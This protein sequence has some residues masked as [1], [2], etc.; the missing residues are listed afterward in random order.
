[1]LS[2]LIFL[3]YL[4]SSIRFSSLLS[5]HLL[6]S[7]LFF[8]HLPCSP[9]VS[10]FLFASYRISLHLLFYS[11]L[12]FFSH[13]CQRDVDAVARKKAIDDAAAAATEA[14][15]AITVEVN[16]NVTKRIETKRNKT[17][18][19]GHITKVSFHHV[20]DFPPPSHLAPI[21]HYFFIYI[22]ATSFTNLVSSDFKLLDSN[23]LT[24]LALHF[25]I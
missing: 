25:V 2:H 16:S 12:L 18:R 19:N 7:R 20:V 5:F 23:H 14:A 21:R 3:P 10:F 1:M 6:P 15:H 17:K 22:S 8:F 24:R 13:L 4:Y 11:N 9:F